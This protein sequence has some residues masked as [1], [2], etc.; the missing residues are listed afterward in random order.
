MDAR[1]Q[2]LQGARRLCPSDFG[3]ERDFSD[4][5]PFVHRVHPRMRGS[6]IKPDRRCQP[7]RGL[8]CTCYTSGSGSLGAEMTQGTVQLVAGILAVALIAIVI[9]RRKGKKAKG[10]DEEF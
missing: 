3:A 4:H 1:K 10:D 7:F 8:F 9:L 6:F 2:S 5:V